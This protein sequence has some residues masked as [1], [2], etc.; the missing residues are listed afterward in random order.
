MTAAAESPVVVRDA[1]PARVVT[2]RAIFTT[3]RVVITRDR[4]LV[5]VDRGDPVL[6][7]PYDPA[8]STVPRYNAPSSVPSTLA[9][10]DGTEVIVTRQRGCGCSSRLRGWRPWQP[11]R[12]AAP[13]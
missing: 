6:D 5:Y 3:A 11:Y 13:A 1:F 4:L 10:L 8:R 9:L 2:P 12:V 7:E